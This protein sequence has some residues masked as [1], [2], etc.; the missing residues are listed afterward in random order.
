MG[1]FDPAKNKWEMTDRATITICETFGFQYICAEDFDTNAASFGFPSNANTSPVQSTECTGQNGERWYVRNT[2]RRVAGTTCDAN[3]N[4]KACQTK[5]EC[6][7]CSAM[8]PTHAD[9]NLVKADVPIL[10]AFV[11]DGLKPIIENKEIK[12]SCPA[13]FHMQSAKYASQIKKDP[14]GECELHSLKIRC[15]DDK[16]TTTDAQYEPFWTTGRTEANSNTERA[17]WVLETD[18]TTRGPKLASQEALDLTCVAVPCPVGCPKPADIPHG[19]PKWLGRDAAINS[20]PIARGELGGN[21]WDARIDIDKNPRLHDWVSYECDADYEL[22]Y[23]DDDSVASIA[24]C[25]RQCYIPRNDCGNVAKPNWADDASTYPILDP[26]NC[27]CAPKLCNKPDDTTPGAQHK[28]FTEKETA[29]EIK[30]FTYYPVSGFN[31]LDV[32]CKAA[33]AL[34]SAP[35]ET[36]T[37][38][39]GWTSPSSTCKNHACPDPRAKVGTY[40]AKSA[41]VA[42]TCASLDQAHLGGENDAWVPKADASI[43]FAD[44]DTFANWPFTLEGEFSGTKI[45]EQQTATMLNGSKYRFTCKKGFSPYM[46]ADNL[47]KF[48]RTTPSAS[49]SFDCVCNNGQW[50]CN[51]YCRCDGFCDKFA[52]DYNTLVKNIKDDTL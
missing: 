3:A 13:G 2:L 40:W 41:N 28:F 49:Q 10:P 48:G 25:A 36:L 1:T 44:V 23:T 16:A 31:T 33:N 38:N 7:E 22:R 4:T 51:E 21:E 5:C 15:E 20:V 32:E 11:D 26:L 8:E 18:G 42:H 46:N 14:D 43:I 35:S 47:M 17:F 19:T 30:A 12:Y 9:Q 50:V 52:Q 29:D 27:Y 39:L 34:A 37:C 6:T 45:K 24:G